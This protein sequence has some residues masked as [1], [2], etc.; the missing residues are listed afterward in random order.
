MPNK[1]SP[2]TPRH[3]LLMYNLFK[4]ENLNLRDLRTLT[5][6]ILAYA[7]FLR[8]REVSVLKRDDIDTQDAYEIILGAKQDRLY[9]SGH[10]IY[11]SKLNSVLCPVKIIQKYIQTVKILKGTSEYL[12]WG[13]VKKNS[14]YRLRSINK[15]ITYTSV[16]ED[17]SEY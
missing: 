17:S 14:S 9:R 1:K 5:I 8:F 15:P 13:I 3:L 16:R 11:I 2:I 7:G 6:C 10:W 4:R 12:F